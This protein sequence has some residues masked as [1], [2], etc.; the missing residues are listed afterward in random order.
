MDALVSVLIVPE[1]PS[2]TETRFTYVL[3]A[4]SKNIIGRAVKRIMPRTFGC[5]K[6][7]SAANAST[8]TTNAALSG[9][10]IKDYKDVKSSR[11][12]RTNA[13]ENSPEMDWKTCVTFITCNILA[14]FES[15]V[16]GE[17]GKPTM[18]IDELMDRWT[19]PIGVCLEEYWKLLQTFDVMVEKWRLL[20]LLGIRPGDQLRKFARSQ[21]LQL[22]AGMVMHFDNKYSSPGLS[23]QKLTTDQWSK[24][25][26]NEMYE[27]MI[28]KRACCKTVFTADFASYFPTAVAMQSQLGQLT[29]DVWK[30]CKILHSLECERGHSQERCDLAHAAAPGK[31]FHHHADR[32]FLLSRLH[33]HA[34][35][36]GMGEPLKALGLGH[37]SGAGVNPMMP[38][39]LRFESAV[40]N[41][42]IVP[43]ELGIKG[44][45]DE[46]L[47][48]NARPSLLALA[49]LQRP[50]RELQDSIV[51]GDDGAN[52]SEAKKQSGRG[53]NPLFAL[54]NRRMR[55]AALAK[56]SPLTP[57][58]MDDV[59]EQ[60]RK[61]IQQEHVHAANLAAYKFEVRQRRRGECLP[62][63]R[64]NAKVAASSTGSMVTAYKPNLGAGDAR[65]PVTANQFCVHYAV[66]G[67]FPSNDDVYRPKTGYV[68]RDTDVIPLS[69]M[70][71]HLSTVSLKTFRGFF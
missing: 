38:T 8:M 34:A 46:P 15:K 53:G 71:G 69:D 17:K 59:R 33:L 58:E 27:A 52:A 61:D 63:S 50:M 35:S 68:I 55:A 30:K 12:Q 10:S 5:L 67:G 26:Q 43:S 32:T 7:D 49:D 48:W 13:F 44:L 9:A 11:Q 23:M 70:K 37:S 1:A 31:T 2:V 56:G 45:D 40:E 21:I 51:A 62:T 42:G 18:H 36:G 25:E 64:S 66:T 19:S 20:G 24:G 14:A 65:L 60:A 3:K 16:M 22:S 47:A 54:F 57:T 28:D 29:L 6:T 41:L 4:I 39:E